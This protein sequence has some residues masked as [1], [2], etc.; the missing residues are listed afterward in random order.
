MGGAMKYF[1][2]NYWTMKYLRLWSPG[3]R[4]FFEKF[5]YQA[6]CTHNQKSQ[7]KNVNILGT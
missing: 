1:L 2:K 6:V 5:P 3:L 7:D 4:N